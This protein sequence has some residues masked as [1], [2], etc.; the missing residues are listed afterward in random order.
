MPGKRKTDRKERDFYRT[1]PGLTRAFLHAWHPKGFEPTRILEPAAGDGAMIDPLQ[2]RFP[3]ALVEAFDVTPQNDRV[4]TSSMFFAE[5]ADHH[6]DLVMTNPPFSHALQF[7][8]RGL[9]LLRENG[10][11]VLLLRLAFLA[12][13]KRVAFF[14]RHLPNEVWVISERQSFV[15]GGTTD[16]SDHAF[17]VWKQGRPPKTFRGRHLHY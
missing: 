3:D 14:R 7:A 8:E 11:L 10:R 16:W 2:E 15:A 1:P 9:E 13:R 4:E 17:F 6:Y 12:S 5:Y